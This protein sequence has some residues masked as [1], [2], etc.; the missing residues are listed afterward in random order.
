M[1]EFRPRKLMFKAWNIESKLLMRLSAIECRRGELIKKDHIILQFTGL[2]DMEGEEI[3]EMDLLL[4]GND[5][6]LT[7]WDDERNGWIA[8]DFPSRGNPQPLNK[9]LTEST[10]RLWSFFESEKDK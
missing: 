10:K 3:Y 8:V 1:R 6:L 2:Y 7:I 4:K 9:I 5:K